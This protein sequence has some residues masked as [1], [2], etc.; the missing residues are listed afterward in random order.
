MKE[1]L[2]TIPVLEEHRRYLESIGEDMHFTYASRKEGAAREMVERA[3]YILGNVKTEYLPDARHLQFLQLD[4]AGANEYVRP[5]VLPPGVKLCN[6]TGAYGVTIAEYLIGVVFALKKKLPL[7]EENRKKHS[8]H[9]EGMVTNIAGSKTLVLGL[10]D[11][12]DTF[13][14]KM[15]ALGSKVTGVR[16]SPADKPEYLEGLYQMDAL[17][18]LLPCAD[19]VVCT[20][21]ETPE[22]CHLL[23]ERK[24]RL[25]KPE[26]VLVN[27]GRGSL[28]PTQDLI[29]VLKDGVIAGAAID[30]AEQEP[31][32]EDSLLWD[33]PNL[34]I[35]P[36]VAGNYHT[37]DILERAVKIA[38]E[39]FQ[40]FLEG[41]PL[42]NEVDFTTGY[43]KRV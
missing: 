32:P 7:Y 13:A 29:R 3:D 19:I 18:E 8:W 31:L 24:L 1:V 28:I 12:G 26:A 35:T 6:A 11:I 20:L 42:R 23:D 39:N 41:R 10:G 21:P 4:S 17:E 38:G 36:H 14:R 40:A 34:M 5:G 16:R 37:Q 43:R 33:T 30:V 22:T 25:M 9:D 2:V 27:V 15:N